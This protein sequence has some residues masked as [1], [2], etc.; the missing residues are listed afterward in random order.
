MT[1]KEL[2]KVEHVCKLYHATGSSCTDR[3]P[4]TLPYQPC[5]CDCEN[6]DC[7]RRCLNS[8]EKCGQGVPYRKTTYQPFLNLEECFNV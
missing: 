7:K 5:C 1:K 4:H 3:L 6:E 2:V 8:V